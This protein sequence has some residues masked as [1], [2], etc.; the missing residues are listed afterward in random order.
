MLSGDY[1]KPVYEKP[2]PQPPE[3]DTEVGQNINMAKRNNEDAYNMSL[4][5]NST[6][7]EKKKYYVLDKD[8]MNVPTVQA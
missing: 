8:Y 3:F 5:S 2:L 7:Y 4:S 1:E 6:D